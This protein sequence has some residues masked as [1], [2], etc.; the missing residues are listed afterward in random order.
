M[1][2]EKAISRFIKKVAQPAHG[3]ACWTWTASRKR[4][5]YGAMGFRGRVWTAH[6][7]SWTLFVGEI[8]PDMHV[9]HRCDNKSCVNFDHLFLGTNADNVADATAKGRQNPG[10]AMEWWA[11]HPERRQRGENAGTVKLSEVQVREIIALKGKEQQRPTARR[12][13]VTQA[14]IS[15]IQRRELWAHLVV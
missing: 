7:I 9:L 12:Y 6:R 14:L 15:K 13:G 5:G 11:A 1:R 3:G 2:D 8:H 4:K 10:P